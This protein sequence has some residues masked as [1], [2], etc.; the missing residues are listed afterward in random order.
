MRMVIYHLQSIWKSLDC[1]ATSS[2]AKS[3][4]I[5]VVATVRRSFYLF[6][7]FHEPIS[8]RRADEP[9]YS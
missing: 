3:V 9:L 2:R 1:E 7:V 5:V 6:S 4:R 8:S